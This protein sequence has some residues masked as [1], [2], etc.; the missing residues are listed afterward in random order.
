MTFNRLDDLALIGNGQVNALLDST[1]EVVWCCWPRFDSDAPFC[2]LLAPTE[3]GRGSFSVELLG[4]SRGDIAYRRNTAIVE[5]R[6]FDD[7]GNAMAVTSFCP[8]FR[9]HE[10]N[11]RPAML[12]RRIVPLAGRPRV[13]ITLRPAEGYGARDVPARHGS[14]HVRF[15]GET[16]SLRLTTDASI[17]HLLEGRP[18]VLDRPITLVISEDETLPAA[19][20]RLYDE[21]EAHTE[22]YWRN[23]VRGLA[24]PFE[25]QDA[26]IRAAI[27]LKLC[28]FEDTGAIIAAPTTSIPE[29]PGTGR[30]WDYRYC[31]LRDAY[32]TV[33]ALNRLGATRTMQSY[34]RYIENISLAEPDGVLQPVYGITG[35][36]ELTESTATAL[37]GFGGD[38][39]VRLGNAAYT[40]VQNDVYGSVILASTQIFFDGRLDEPGDRGRFERLERLGIHALDAANMPDASLWEYRGRLSRHTFSAAMC[41]AAVDRLA[42][43]AAH[44]G[45]Q[46]PARRWRH[47][48]SQL[49]S[50][51]LNAAWS[52]RLGCLSADLDGDR[53]D[54]S[55]LLLPELGLLSWRDTR[56]VRTLERVEQNLSRQGL[57]QRYAD[58]DD[59]GRSPNAFT[60][61]SFWHANALWEVGRRDDARVLLER[62]LGARNRCGLLA[63]DIDPSTGGPWGNF[64]QTYSMVG[65]ITS[66]MRLSRR[67]ED[68]L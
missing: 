36:R 65:I 7:A 39:P 14:H 55:L 30:T 35:E 13:R 38:G 48:A 52:E 10:R 23:W 26:T 25:W 21:F 33:Q 24:I 61:C 47:E 46:D 49:G 17:S 68:A 22:L 66:A 44:L 41:W 9:R 34:L 3:A 15:Q 5:T 6:S 32:F 59:F 45:L 43:I 11:F 40:Q 64:P 28:A 57:L 42:K 56:F 2:S 63:E 18:F 50:R 1:G 51:I 67:W 4:R 20:E 12:L 8:R 27:T 62:L 37:A 31:W 53:L 54:A 60:V 29:A 19:P 16:L 58:A